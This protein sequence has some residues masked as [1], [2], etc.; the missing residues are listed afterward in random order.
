[1]QCLCGVVCTMLLWGAQYNACVVCYEVLSTMLV[2]NACVVWGKE[3][4]R[5]F[6]AECGDIVLL[7]QLNN[8]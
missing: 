1:V 6:L 3:P 7:W 8:T 4:K 5:R 2:H